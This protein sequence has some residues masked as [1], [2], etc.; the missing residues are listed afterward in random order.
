V[1]QLS[2][3]KQSNEERSLPLTVHWRDAREIRKPRLFFA[4]SMG[5]RGYVCI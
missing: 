2:K 3:A 1:Y 5:I 4:F